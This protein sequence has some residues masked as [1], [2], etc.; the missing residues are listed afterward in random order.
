MTFHLFEGVE[1]AAVGVDVVLVDLVG[2]DEEMVL[3]SELDDDLDVL[4]KD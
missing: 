4:P 1:L 2:E 3:V